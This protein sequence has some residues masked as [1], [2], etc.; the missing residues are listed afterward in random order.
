[1]K[2]RCV[3]ITGAD[4]GV[5]IADLSRMAGQYP[6][7]EWAILFMP[8]MAG[9]ARA[10]SPGW[11][12]N[13]VATY[14]GRHM[15]MHLCGSAL[16][17]FAAGKPEIVD[18]MRGFR[19]IQ[20]NLEFGDV[21][22]RYDMDALLAQVSAHPQFEF[23]FQ[24]TDKRHDLLPRLAGIKSHALLFDASAGRGVAPDCWPAPIDGHACGYAG[25]INPGNVAAHLDKIA[26]AGVQ[27]TWIDMESGV[28]TDDH[29]DLRKVEDV[30]RQCASFA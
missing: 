21:E 9:Q 27:E 10:P 7:V 5:T 18:M 3:S 16:T 8:E 14:R 12:R 1:M 29:F 13:F 24:Y 25:G 30:L 19:R 15:A 22:G 6:F 20:L 23:I 17:G 2:L 28:R 4:D 11:I 26:A